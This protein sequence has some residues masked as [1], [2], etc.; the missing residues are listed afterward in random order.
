MTGRGIGYWPRAAR[1]AAF[2][3]R[4]QMRQARFGSCQSARPWIAQPGP[5]GPRWAWRWQRGGS[6]APR[7]AVTGMRHTWQRGMRE[8]STRIGRWGWTPNTRRGS[9]GGVCTPVCEYRPLPS[10][11]YLYYY[12]LCGVTGRGWSPSPDPPTAPCSSG[13]NRGCNPCRLVQLHAPRF[14]LRY[15]V[16]PLPPGRRTQV[17]ALT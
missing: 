17:R 9:R 2:F 1:L 6:S 12:F 11:Y 8:S 3:S 7:E 4:L 5:S 14:P 16:H 15:G 13:C 10:S